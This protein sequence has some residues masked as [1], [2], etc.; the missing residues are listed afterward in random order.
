MA[1]MKKGFF[2]IIGVILGFVCVVLIKEFM[3]SSSHLPPKPPYFIESPNKEYRVVKKD[4]IF[5]IPFVHEGRGNLVA[6]GKSD[7]DLSPYVDKIVIMDIAYPKN[8]KELFR[9]ITQKQCTKSY[10]VYIYPNDKKF[11]TTVNVKNIR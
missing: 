1:G 6:V 11:A 7:Y 2:I 4:G 9:Y 3:F 8:E 10:C 5:Y